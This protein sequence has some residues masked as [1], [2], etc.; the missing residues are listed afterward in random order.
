MEVTKWVRVQGMTLQVFVCPDVEGECG[1]GA[2][3][4]GRQV[5]GSGCGAEPGLLRCPREGPGQGL[6]LRPLKAHYS[7]FP[8][9]A[10]LQHRPAW[11]NAGAQGLQGWPGGSPRLPCVL[12]PET[13]GAA[14]GLQGKD[15]PKRS[16]S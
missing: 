16:V 7:F 10:A 4:V 15:N 3:A 8:Q 9:P 2:G 6:G 1:K 13:T 11:L 5:P 12:S 14:S